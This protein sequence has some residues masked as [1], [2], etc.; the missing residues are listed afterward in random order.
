MRFYWF[1]SS[2]GALPIDF[3]FWLILLEF[4][5]IEETSTAE[6]HRTYFKEIHFVITI[7]I[8]SYIISLNK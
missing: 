2:L 5:N 6:S 7:L 3:Y 8:L 4:Q 1:V